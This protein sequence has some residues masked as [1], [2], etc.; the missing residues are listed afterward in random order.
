MYVG[1]VQRRQFERPILKT[2]WLSQVRQQHDLHLLRLHHHSLYIWFCRFV[3]SSI[4]PGRRNY[5]QHLT[6][7]HPA[8]R[9]LPLL[10]HLRKWNWP[11]SYKDPLPIHLSSIS[12]SLIIVEFSVSLFWEFCNKAFSCDLVYLTITF[13]SHIQKMSYL[14]H[15]LLPSHY[16]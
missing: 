4:L 12:Q 15:S 2:Y 11:Q 1:G 14:A 13:S 6:G 7:Y 16:C 8:L 9:R 10:Y 5:S 3:C